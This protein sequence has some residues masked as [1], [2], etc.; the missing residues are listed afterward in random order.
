MLKR[1][2][3]IYC[4]RNSH[5][6]LHIYDGRLDTTFSYRERYTILLLYL[7]PANREPLGHN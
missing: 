5:G 4:R 2:V 3:H 6:F 7:N 1:V